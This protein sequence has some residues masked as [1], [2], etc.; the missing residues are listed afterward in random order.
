MDGALVID[1]PPGMTSHDVVL[2]ARRLLGEKRIGHLGTLDPFATGVLVLLVGQ[3]TRLARFYGAR[4]KSYR[5]IIRFGFTTDT[6]DRTGRSLADDC[7][8]ELSESKLRSAFSEFVGRY[9]QQPPSFSAKKVAGV[10][11]YRL[12]RKG[13]TADLAPV[14][15]VVHTLDLLWI[16]GPRVGFEARV[17]SGTYIRSLVHDVGERMEVGANLEELRRSSVGEFRE[18]DSLSVKRLQEAV[19]QR[20][21]ILI[22]MTELLPEIPPVSLDE[23]EAARIAHGIDLE[24]HADAERLRLFNPEGG[25]IAIAERITG[26]LYH[27]IVVLAG[28]QTGAPA[29]AAAKPAA[30]TEAGAR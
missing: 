26:N 27:P 2:L 13:Q 9:L 23:L 4:E 6:M 3:A 21:Q 30:A 5:G 1:K 7:R 25:L 18:Q 10:P 8:P 28:D 16:E 15:V 12:A 24:L 11:A 22:P 19:Q 20:A 29:V 14:P 17:S